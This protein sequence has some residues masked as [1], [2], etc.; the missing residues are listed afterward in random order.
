MRRL[1]FPALCAAVALARVLE[2]RASRRHVRRLTARG[3]R[4][5]DEPAFAAMVAVHAATLT[6][7]PIEAQLRARRPHPAVA[8]TALA[9]LGAAAALRVWTLRTLGDAWS[10]RVLRFVDLRRPIVVGGP[11][12]YLRHPNYLAVIIELVALPLV[13]GAWR[14]ALAATVANALVLARRIAVEER[15]LFDDARYRAAFAARPRLLPRV[16]TR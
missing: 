6:A 2:L 13:G 3:G 12:R 14:T 10:V 5:V 16:F 1:A 8:A 15:E 11:Y 4:V 7:A 9:A